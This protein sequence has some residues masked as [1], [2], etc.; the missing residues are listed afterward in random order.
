VEAVRSCLDPFF[1]IVRRIILGFAI[2]AGVAVL[3]M[4]GVTVLDVVLRI[5]KV[6]IIGAYD[7]VRICGALAISC[8]LPYITAV[9]GHIAI[10]FLHRRIS[11]SGR[12]AV[13]VLFRLI[14][15][16]LFGFLM[17]QNVRY[18]FSLRAAGEQMPTLK[19]SV[20]WIPMIIAVNAL[21]VCLVLIYH[22]LHPDE[23]MI[24]S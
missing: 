22:L 14:A 19:V 4:M 11:G 6:G 9:K 3:V 7:I 20:F 18:G 21:L 1:R 13:D 17:V 16:A 5:F 2:A 8:A 23:E 12:M 15:L 10:E 24:V